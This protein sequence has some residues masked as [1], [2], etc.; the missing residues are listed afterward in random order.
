MG[1]FR[2][3]KFFTLTLCISP[4]L[5]HVNHRHCEPAVASTYII[6][7]QA[8]TE[9]EA[10]A[11]QH[12]TLYL[13]A[14]SERSLS[15]CVHNELCCQVPMTDQ[16]RLCHQ[17][18]AMSGSGATTGVTVVAASPVADLIIGN[19][20]REVAA[21]TGDAG[22]KQI[23]F[24][25]H[26]SLADDLSLCV[27]KDESSWGQYA[28]MPAE[29]VAACW[30]G[31]NAYIFADPSTDQK[32]QQASSY[33]VAN[34]AVADAGGPSG[35]FASAM[36]HPAYIPVSSAQYPSAF[37]YHP[38]YMTGQIC[39]PVLRLPPLSEIPL[40]QVMILS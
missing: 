17:T 4:V 23:K 37:T 26:E 40:F 21:A 11:C 36:M 10:E 29:T 22:G 14:V 19:R 8:S 32:R 7:N 34:A 24:S 35:C 13:A 15:C 39:L 6:G 5:Q 2:Q 31:Q 28:T 30:K 33:E 9:A 16:H 27:G 38:G 18:A 25:V 3:A 20:R 12:H 1:A